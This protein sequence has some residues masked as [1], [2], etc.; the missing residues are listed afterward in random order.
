MRRFRS[1]LAVAVVVVLAACAQQAAPTPET[2]VLE[3]AATITIVDE[4][5]NASFTPIFE[6]QGS[7][8]ATPITGSVTTQGI[9][10]GDYEG[11]SPTLRGFYLQDPDGDGDPATSDGIFVFN[12]N[13][14]RSPWATSCASPARA[15]EF[16]DQTQIAASRRSSS[17]APAPSNRSTSPCRSPRHV[18][19]ALRGH[20]R[21][22]PAD[23]VRHRA[24]PA[25]PLR[26][27]GAVRRATGCR[28]RPRSPT[29]A[30]RPRRCRPRTTC[31]RIIVDDALNGQNPDPIVFGRGGQ[32]CSASNTLRGGDTATG[33]VG[34]LTYTWAA[35]RR[36]ATPTGCA[37]SARS[38][39]ASTS[40]PR[41]RARR[42]TPPW[43]ASCG[44][45]AE[46]AQLLQHVRRPP[47]RRGQL[48]QRRRRRPDRLPRRRR[49]GRVRAPGPTR[50]SPPSWRSTSTC[51]A[52][53][54]SRTTATA[55]TAR[56]RTS[57][58]G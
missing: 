5:C 55:P 38:A 13:E 28:S 27:G 58:T 15:G 2:E 53:S 24:L 31:N 1:F 17:A 29:R 39:A 20:A 32:P 19:R 35:T 57:S 30:P 3:A 44:W 51:S 8:A 54:R 46:R 12:G 16:Q 40:R 22:L 4:R 23:A 7:G 37:R 9:V 36:A 43:A 18:P 21:A 11:P 10:V 26:P 48:H 6:I 56:S 49:R 33:I 41:T 34:V 45:R 50:S 52:S 25:R 14:R 42:R 47:R